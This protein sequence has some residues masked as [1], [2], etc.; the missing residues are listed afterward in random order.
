V[1][2]ARP[3]YGAGCYGLLTDPS[4][5]RYSSVIDAFV[6]GAARGDADR[7]LGFQW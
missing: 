3:F 4:R 5:R 2:P 1:L 6:G 7:P